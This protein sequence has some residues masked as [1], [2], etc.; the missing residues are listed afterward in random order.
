MDV[1]SLPAMS[2]VSASAV[3]SAGG[4]GF[5]SSSRAFCSFASRSSRSLGC[6]RRRATAATARPDRL[7]TERWP[8][9]NH[10]RRR[11]SGRIHGSSTPMVAE[12]SPRS[13]RMRM[14]GTEIVLRATDDDEKSLSL[15]AAMPPTA[16]LAVSAHASSMPN[17]EP[18]A[19]SGVV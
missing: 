2:C 19:R 1:V 7:R 9:A 11:T 17:G 13:F 8:C 10:G 14:A 12:Y 18:N 16:A 3:S 15:S 6:A 4:I 5:P